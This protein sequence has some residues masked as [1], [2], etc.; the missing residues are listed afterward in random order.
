MTT[1]LTSRIAAGTSSPTVSIGFVVRNDEKYIRQALESLLAQ[2]YTD[3]EL[4]ISDNAS[5]DD[6]STICQEYARRDPRITYVCQNENIGLTK[7]LEYALKNTRGQ[8]FMWAASDDIWHPDF[9][10]TLVEALQKKPQAALSFAPYAWIDDKGDLLKIK[11]VDYSGG[12]AFTRL[13][14][15]CWLYD[16]GCFYGLFRRKF[17][18][19]F[20]FATW[21][22]I[23]ASNPVNNAYPLLCYALAAGEFIFC[24]VDPLWQNRIHLRKGVVNVRAAYTDIRR[25]NLFFNYLNFILLKIN[26]LYT[27]VDAVYRGC[28][29]RITTVLILPAL[30]L[31]CLYDCLYRI[32]QKYRASLDS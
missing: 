19:D 16:D 27:C 15:F 12:S 2:S 23:N 14:K 13:L 9:L 24:K 10:K 20:S 25:T 4:T 32:M 8:F 3:F 1:N 31:R 18:A 28:Q 5:T 30:S 11:S 17:V 29:S 26:V 21:W 22:G 7:N 6:T